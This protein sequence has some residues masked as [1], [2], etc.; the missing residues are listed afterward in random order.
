MGTPM[1]LNLSRR[2]PITVWNRS[3]SKYPP[4]VRAGAR[5]GTTPADVAKN[6][7]VIFTMLFDASAINDILPSLLQSS[8]AGKT[9]VN[10]SSVPEDFSHYLSK[11]ITSAGG[12][13]VE[14]PVSGSKQP[15][16]QG[17][18]VA[19]LSGSPPAV[20]AI[21]P[22]VEN[23]IC[24]AAIYCGPIGCALRAKY[25]VNLYIIT[26]AVGLAEAMNLARAQGLDVAVLGAV[27]NAG[28]ASSAY[29][30]SK[31]AK[32]VTGDWMPQATARDCWNSS[33][34]ICEAAETAEA[35]APLIRACREMFAMAVDEGGWGDED[36]IAVVKTMSHFS[37]N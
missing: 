7:D 1:A 17:R 36:L 3:A 11:T 20:E 19:M 32:I 21:R 22:V 23:T 27:I 31:I 9:L 10:S 24:S 13:F 8:L 14:M 6:S 15:A 34:L 28:P 30:E 33:K 2:F 5:I 4:L 26:V 18:L 29:T 37:A 12:Q 25:A 16:E 35:G